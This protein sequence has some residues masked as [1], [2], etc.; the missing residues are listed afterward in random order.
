MKLINLKNFVL[1]IIVVVGALLRFYKLSQIPNGFYIDE[2][3]IGY[4]SYS[5]LKTGEDEY[6]KSFPIFLKS[7]NAYSSPLYA[8]LS[9]IPIALFGLNVFSVRFLSAFLGSLSILIFYGIL[10]KIKIIKKD[11]IRLLGAFIFAIS[12]WNIF[13]SRGAYEAN[14][15]LFMILLSF[16]LFLDESKKYW[17]LLLSISVLSLSTY[18]Y[19]ANRLISFTLL[20][21]II[22]K[23][24]RKDLL[25]KKNIIAVLIFCVIQIPQFVLLFTPAFRSRAVGLFYI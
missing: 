13:F 21:L 10:G 1:I 3:A 6:G 4:N 25:N 7:F 8:Y 16:Y 20:P 18:A 11:Y 24:G 22:V 12:P 2:A 14:L 17:K 15:V 23:R 19:Q 5:L 9:T